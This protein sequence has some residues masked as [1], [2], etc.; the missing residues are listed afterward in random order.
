MALLTIEVRK[1][2]ATFYDD[3]ID[4]RNVRPV[5]VGFSLLIVPVQLAQAESPPTPG[6]PRKNPETKESRVSRIPCDAKFD[7]AVNYSVTDDAK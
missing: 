7:A 5:A 4:S 2:D 3:R 6:N 1:N